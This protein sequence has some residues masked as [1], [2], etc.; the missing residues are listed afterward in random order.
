MAILDDAA[1]SAG[2]ADLHDWRQEPGAVRRTVE[3]PDFMSGIALV[4]A[5]A[6]EAEEA[7]HHPD[8]DIRYT[9]VTFTLSS[10]DVGGVTERDLDMAARID[11]LAEQGAG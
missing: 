11:R 1:I 3:A 7:N 9:R 5:V 4:N 2:L 10:H 6:R 8:V